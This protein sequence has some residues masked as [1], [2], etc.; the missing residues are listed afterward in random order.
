MKKT[1]LIAVLIALALL[2]LY[3]IF[4]PDGAALPARAEVRA[5]IEQ[6]IDETDRGGMHAVIREHFP[7]AYEAHIAAMT[8]L[9]LETLRDP[10]GPSRDAA[11][12][13]GRT[14]ATT[15]RHD[16]AHF[17]DQAPGTAVRDVIAARLT[18]LESLQ[19]DPALCASVAAFGGA[20]LSLEQAERID[21][22]LMSRAARQVFVAIAAGRDA[23]VARD[24]ATPED[25]QQL[26]QIWQ[27]RSTGTLS[28]EARAG[29]L[30]GKV[31]TPGYC[32]AAV[33]FFTLLAKDPSAMTDR[34]AA[35]FVRD[36]AGS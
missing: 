11:F 27:D 24:P 32:D 26:R 3:L 9:T 1:Q 22:D 13:R 35:G 16:N 36:M 20:R 23:P 33:S 4:R 19:D 29:F 28:P 25:L 18:L 12:E 15:L 10:E 34:V 31:E 21:L 6:K 8:D 7:E 14:F 17:I 30:A 5:L 2:G